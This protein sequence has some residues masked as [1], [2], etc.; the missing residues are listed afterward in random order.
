MVSYQIRSWLLFVRACTIITQRTVKS[1]DIHTADNLLL[2]FCRSVE[3]L[4]GHQYCTPNMHLHLHLKETLLDFGPAHTTWCFSFERYNGILGEMTTNKKGIEV[5]FMRKFLKSQQVYSLSCGISDEELVKI[6]PRTTSSQFSLS[7][8]VT[9]DS[10]LLNLLKLSHG[11]L[12][13][14]PFSYVDNA[15]IKLL[16]LSRES[17]FTSID[18]NDLESLYSQLNPDCTVDYISPFYH[19]H[20]TISVGGDILGSKL[21]SRSA[22]SSSVVTAYWPTHGRNI[23]SFDHSRASVG[24]VQHYVNHAVTIKDNH[25]TSQIVTYTLAYVHWMNLHHQ[26]TMYGISATVCENSECEP[27]LCS[28]IPVLRIFAKCAT[29]LNTLNDETVLI[30]CPIPLKLS[31]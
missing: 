5:Q 3:E 7:S 9:S 6:L 18:I 30:A 12:E 2:M 23:N 29:C 31:I 19:C 17:V 13:P 21:N 15:H 27:S 20:G 24:R 16:G 22:Q 25:G 4:Y 8:S 26:S 14:R 1:S 11:L 10:E 28:F